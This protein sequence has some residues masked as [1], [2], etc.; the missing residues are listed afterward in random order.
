MMYYCVTALI[1]WYKGGDGL[2]WQLKTDRPIYAQLIELIELQIVSGRY[3][4]GDR[5]PAVRDMASQAE[6]NP[7]TMQKALA[8][9][10]R[11]G[12]VFTQR[13][14]GR[15]ITEDEQMIKKLK[16][17]LAKMQIDDF[18]EKMDSLGFSKKETLQMLENVMEE[19]A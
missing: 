9:L 18:L 10:E 19:G 16:D 7:N 8:E 1:Q 3:Q 2:N 13:T 15:F 12:L 14:S 17:L 4:P 5:L 6:V 11:K